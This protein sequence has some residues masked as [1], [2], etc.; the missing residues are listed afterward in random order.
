MAI[1]IYISLNLPKINHLH[2]LDFENL[3][4]Y[5]RSRVLSV[6]RKTFE[7]QALQTYG[8]QLLYKNLKIAKIK[9][10]RENATKSLRIR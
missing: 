5:I 10:F 2:V 9:K 4:K 3:Y 1:F 7:F 6:Y 8:L